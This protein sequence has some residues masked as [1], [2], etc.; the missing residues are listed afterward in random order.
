MIT[1]FDK[2][3]NNAVRTQSD[4]QE[5]LAKRQ[6]ASTKNESTFRVRVLIKNSMIKC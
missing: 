5:E 3:F 6:K 4:I 1:S 2:E